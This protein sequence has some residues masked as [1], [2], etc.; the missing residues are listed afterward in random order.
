MIEHPLAVLPNDGDQLA[1]LPNDRLQWLGRPTLASTFR[2]VNA[3]RS[4]LEVVQDQELTCKRPAQRSRRTATRV[5]PTTRAAV[6][7]VADL[8][9]RIRADLDLLR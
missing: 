2:E 3:G 7:M 8:A 9:N 4:N 5:D 1:A 6:H